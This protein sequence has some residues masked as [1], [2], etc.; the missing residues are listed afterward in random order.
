MFHTSSDKQAVCI[1]DPAIDHANTKIAEYANRRDMS[2]IAFLP[3][4]KPEIYHLRPI[5]HTIG[6]WIDSAPNEQEKFVRSFFAC[7]IRVTNFVGHDGMVHD[8][9]QPDRMRLDGQRS[10]ETV[11]DLYTPAEKDLFPRAT[12]YEIGSVAWGFSFFP[13]RIEPFFPLPPTSKEIWTAEFMRRAELESNTPTTGPIESQPVPAP[14][15][16]APS[17]SAQE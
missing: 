16:T 11:S 12:L 6:S 1:W 5:T 8:I 4:S 14:S 7:V 10:V 2:K 13:K 3:G 15:E 9:W 17:Q